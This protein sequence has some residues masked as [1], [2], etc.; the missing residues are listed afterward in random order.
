MQDKMMEGLTKLLEYLE[1]RA[2][3]NDTRRKDALNA[4]SRALL[5]TELYVARLE[6]GEPK[7][8][9]KEE[10]LARLWRESSLNTKVLNKEWPIRDADKMYHW[11]NHAKE[12]AE[13]LEAR[14]LS[15]KDLRKDLE[16]TL[17]NYS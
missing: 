3:R 7:D 2:D 5:E 8:R 9:K 12:E 13:S 16:Q 4:F 14:G 15:L 6:K 17:N 11:I 10:E 1:R